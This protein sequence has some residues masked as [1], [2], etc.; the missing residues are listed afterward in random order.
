MRF[1]GDCTP[2]AHH[3]T[4]GE[5]GSLGVVDDSIPQIQP[6]PPNVHPPRNSRPYDQGLFRETNG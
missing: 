2:L 4:F 6:T 1:G 3:L 5:P